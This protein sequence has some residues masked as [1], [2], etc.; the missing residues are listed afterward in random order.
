MR[1]TKPPEG[2][3]Q[4]GLFKRGGSHY[5]RHRVPQDLISHYGKREFKFSLGSKEALVCTI[6]A[7]VIYSCDPPDRLER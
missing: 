5:F 2:M 4:T 1:H 3:S 6:S 7:A